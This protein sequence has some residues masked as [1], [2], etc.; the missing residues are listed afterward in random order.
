MPCAACSRRNVVD[1]TNCWSRGAKQ[2]K[3]AYAGGFGELVAAQFISGLTSTV[4]YTV[5]IYFLGHSAKPDRVFGLLMVLQT[6]FFS[7]DAM[8]LP[9]INAH[10]G[11]VITIGSAMLTILYQIF[12]PR[13]P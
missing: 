12:K 2:I 13:C 10:F 9:V 1:A 11:Y 5:A 7:V 6:A 4:A 8:A 3:Y